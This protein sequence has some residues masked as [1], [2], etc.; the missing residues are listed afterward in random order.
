M[1]RVSSPTPSK[2]RRS[3][4]RRNSA[5]TAPIRSS[6]LWARA[7]RQFGPFGERARCGEDRVGAGKLAPRT[8]E[9]LRLDEPDGPAEQRSEK[10]P[11]HHRIHDEVGRH[12]HAPGCEVARQR[13]RHNLRRASRCLSLSRLRSIHS[14]GARLRTGRR[15]SLRANN[16]HRYKATERGRDPHASRVI[17]PSG[18][19][20]AS[21]H[22]FTLDTQRS[23]GRTVTSSTLHH[24]NTVSKKEGIV[25]A[26]VR[27]S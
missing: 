6:G 19:D 12:K 25:Q 2:S 7:A 16:R 8:K 26:L 4:A 1:L 23:D 24:C 14:H 15:R 20:L 10:K 18:P 5:S 22:Q 21:Q 13:F 17:Q 11:D 27:N 3:G 9:L